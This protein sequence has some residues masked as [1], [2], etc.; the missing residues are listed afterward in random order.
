MIPL[1]HPTVVVPV[2]F[3]DD[4]EAAIRSG[5]ERVDDPSGLHVVHVLVPLDY[6]SPGVMFGTISDASREKAIR[7]NLGKILAKIGVAGV[8]VAVPIGDPGLKIT[9]YA[10]DIN[11]DLII[12]PSHGF[13]GVKR[14]LLGSTAERII[15]HAHCSVLVLRRRDAD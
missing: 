12:V 6:A 9:D 14:F 1:K 11:A 4:T 10:K 5:L 15:R 8:Q 2:D 13:H 3:S 7:E